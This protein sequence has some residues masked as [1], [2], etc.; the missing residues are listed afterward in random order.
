MILPLVGS[1][2]ESLSFIVVS[3]VDFYSARH[4]VPPNRRLFSSPREPA[5][6]GSDVRT[7][8][9]VFA[10]TT[11][12]T[13]CISVNLSNPIFVTQV[14]QAHATAGPK[15]YQILRSVQPGDAGYWAFI[16]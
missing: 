13:A 1:T 5:S 3:Y 6:T 15:P 14:L 12:E 7:V 2:V 4:S 8:T 11:A 9:V 10:L 16:A